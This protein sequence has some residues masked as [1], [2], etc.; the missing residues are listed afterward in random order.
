MWLPM[1]LGGYRELIVQYVKRQKRSTEFPTAE[2]PLMCVSIVSSTGSTVCG[3]ELVGVNVT[4]E[5]MR[6]GNKLPMAARTTSI[7]LF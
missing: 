3:V 6:Y 2:S 7:T 5:K 1:V 4:T